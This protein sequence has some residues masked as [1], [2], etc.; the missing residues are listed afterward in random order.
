MKKL[1]KFLKILFVAN[2]GW[3]AAYVLRE[4]LRYKTNPEFYAAFSA[5]W[6]TG[7]LVNAAVAGIITLALGAAI[8]ILKKKRD[9]IYSVVDK[10]I[11]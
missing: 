6:Y 11:L 2:I 8:L 10:E 5:P 1:C 3:F 7:I 4:V 9:S